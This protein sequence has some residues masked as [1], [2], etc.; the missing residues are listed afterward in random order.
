MQENTKIDLLIYAIKCQ[1]LVVN[2]SELIV[3][4]TLKSI[5]D[6]AEAIKNQKL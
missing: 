6:L 5:L 4:K 1:L 2:D 3:Y